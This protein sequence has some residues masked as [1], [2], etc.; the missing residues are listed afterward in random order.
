MH[1]SESNW[2]KK[3]IRLFYTCFVKVKLAL[4]LDSHLVFI[5]RITIPNHFVSSG[6]IIIII[7]FF[8]L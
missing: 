2:T 7:I 4:G 6:G 5:L 1:T 3:V 8:F